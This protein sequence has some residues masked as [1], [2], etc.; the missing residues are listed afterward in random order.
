MWNVQ[1]LKAKSWGQE[2]AKIKNQGFAKSI[3][4]FT[5]IG[6]WQ[7]PI[8]MPIHILVVKVLSNICTPQTFNTMSTTPL[9]PPPPPH[10]WQQQP[11]KV[12][13]SHN[14]HLCLFCCHEGIISLDW[15]FD[16]DMIKHLNKIRRHHEQPKMVLSFPQHTSSLFCFHE[17]ALSLSLQKVWW[18]HDQTSQWNKEM[19]S[20][21]LN[22]FFL[23][24]TFLMSLL[25]WW[26]SCLSSLLTEIWSTV[27]ME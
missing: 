2:F 13:S 12:L 5:K 3:T 18:K 15:K 22:K 16:E 8:C 1:S 25:F 14:T 24:A 9:P 17:G 19:S 6:R 11:K 21:L 26:K 4:F 10:H 20:F 27:S 23:L 7:V